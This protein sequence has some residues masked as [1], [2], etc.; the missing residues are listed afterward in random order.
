[1]KRAGGVV[2]CLVAGGFIASA[3][4][5]WA[6]DKNIQSLAKVRSLKCAFGWYSSTDWDADEPTIK[7]STLEFSR[8][9]DGIDRGR[10]AARIIGNAGADDLA[11]VD[12]GDLLSFIDRTPAGAVNLTTVYAWCDRGGRFK[13]VHSRHTAIGGPSPSQHYGYCESW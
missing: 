8:P 9:I 11:V 5:P 3:A 7:T 12:A 13:A 4:Q 10:R 1:M 6:S 2:A